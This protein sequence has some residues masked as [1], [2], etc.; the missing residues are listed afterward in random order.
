M[1]IVFFYAG[2]LYYGNRVAPNSFPPWVNPS[3]TQMV[4]MP[5]VGAPVLETTPPPHVMRGKGTSTM[6][7]HPRSQLDHNAME[8]LYTFKKSW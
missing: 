3:P 2:T 4:P 5:A 7:L 1:D 8:H 6:L